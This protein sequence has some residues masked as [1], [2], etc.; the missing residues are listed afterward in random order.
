MVF[1]AVRTGTEFL[2]GVDRIYKCS[3]EF[4]M[5]TIKSMCHTEMIQECTMSEDIG[6]LVTQVW[7]LS[8]DGGEDIIKSIF[9][10]DS[11]HE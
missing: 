10:L 3:L 8:L 11:F 9:L 6:L 1:F 7:Q 2:D 4:L 5:C